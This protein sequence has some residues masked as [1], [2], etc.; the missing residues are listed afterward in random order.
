MHERHVL[1]DN[2][3]CGGI[4]V[5]SRKEAMACYDRSQGVI[6]GCTSLR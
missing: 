6:V 1:P 2:G 4:M 5:Y 3:R